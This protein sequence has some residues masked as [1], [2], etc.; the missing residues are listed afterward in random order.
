VQQLG[1]SSQGHETLDSIL[2]ALKPPPVSETNL[3]DALIFAMSH[4]P[5]VTGRKAVIL[6]SSGVDTFSKATFED[7]LAAAKGCD[8]PI[9]MISLAPVLRQAA[10]LHRMAGPLKI[11][12]NGAESKLLEITRISGGR[13]YSPASTVDLSAIYDDIMENLRVRYVVTYKSSSEGD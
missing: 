2:Y 1:D 13:L 7:V 9:Y 12:W 11:E 6:I 3:Y 10:E 4:M 5:R 8:A